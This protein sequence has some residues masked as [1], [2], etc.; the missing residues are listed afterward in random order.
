MDGKQVGIVPTSDARQVAHERNL[1]LVE[2]APKERPPVCQI[3]DYS[4]WKYQQSKKTREKRQKGVERKEIRLS[5]VIELHDIE[6]KAASIRKFLEHG[7]HVRVS[8]E[9]RKGRQLAHPEQ[10]KSVMSQVL[11]L[12][13]DVG[14]VESNPRM[15][16]R[17]LSANLV[18]K[19]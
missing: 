4:K 12:V 2:V 19:T 6:T 14:Q 18:P 15:E 9:F 17:I 3:M 1:D 5:P 10:G 7:K 8:I 16:G 11:A 13:S